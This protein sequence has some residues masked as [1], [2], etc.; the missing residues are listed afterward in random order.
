MLQPLLSVL[1][2]PTN[3][4]NTVNPKA[5]SPLSN[6]QHS[7]LLEVANVCVSE[8]Q[9][10]LKIIEQNLDSTVDRLPPPWYTVFCMPSFIHFVVIQQ[11]SNTRT[12]IHS[13]AIVLLTNVL[14]SSKD[15]NLKDDSSFTWFN[16]CLAALQAYESRSRSARRCR[17]HLLLVKQEFF[18]HRNRTCDPLASLG[19]LSATDISTDTTHAKVS[20]NADMTTTTTCE[21]NEGMVMGS[22]NA[23]LEFSARNHDFF[24][25]QFVHDDLRMDPHPW[26]RNSPDLTRLELGPFVEGDMETIM[27]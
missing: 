19:N 23:E 2:D 14:N 27:G 9:Q 26:M 4:L 6:M 18:N 21:N 7:M 11:Y 13:S 3:Q 17:K 12:D 8:A 16:R 10:I 22:V 15:I 1:C 25:S 5:D 24:L 20:G